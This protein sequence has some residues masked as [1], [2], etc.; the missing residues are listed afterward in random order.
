MFNL[1]INWFFIFSMVS[2]MILL[3][4]YPNETISF[5]FCS[6][7]SFLFFSWFTLTT[8]NDLT[9]F[10]INKYEVRGEIKNPK[11]DIIISK[12]PPRSPIMLNTV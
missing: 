9:D 7:K 10:S 4:I 6:L 2:L 1:I 5:N 12:T 3:Y 11:I 8:K